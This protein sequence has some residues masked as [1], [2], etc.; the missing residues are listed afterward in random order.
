MNIRLAMLA[1]ASLLLAAC[2][3]QPRPLQGEFAQISPRDA[4]SIDRTGALVRWGGASCRSNRSPTAPVS[5]SSP[6]G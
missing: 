1:L 5:R 6:P 3:S 2:A 4:T